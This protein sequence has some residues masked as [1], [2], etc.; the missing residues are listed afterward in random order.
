MFRDGKFNIWNDL[1][2]VSQAGKTIDYIYIGSGAA[3]TTYFDL[4]TFQITEGV[5]DIPYTNYQGS[6]TTITFETPKATTTHPARRM[7]GRWF[8]R[9]GEGWNNCF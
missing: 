6:T 7:G 3:N 4:D 2:V 5:D 9:W 8:G 1:N